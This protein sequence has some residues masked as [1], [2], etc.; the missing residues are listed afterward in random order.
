MNF[1]Y[2]LISCQLEFT[3]EKK[4]SPLQRFANARGRLVINMKGEL[5]SPLQ[6]CMSRRDTP[7]DSILHLESHLF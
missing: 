1:Q 5:P 2:S 3:K 4:P 6:L 7:H